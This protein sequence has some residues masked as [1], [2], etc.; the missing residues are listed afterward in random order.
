MYFIYFIILIGVLIF[1]HE[2]GHFLGAK[3]FKVKVLKLSLGFGPKMVGFRY[4]ETEYVITWFPL[5]GFVKMLGEDPKQEVPPQEMDRCFHL[6]PLWQRFIIVFLG[7][8]F[9]IL[10]PFV[11]YFFVFLGQ[12]TLLPPLVGLVYPDTPA[13]RAGFLPDDRIIA[14]DGNKIYSFEDLQRIISPYPLR[15]FEFLIQRDSERL[16]IEVTAAK[17]KEERIPGIS[18]EVGRIGIS[19]LYLAPR[20]GI[21][22]PSSPFYQAG[23]RTW[24]IVI[25]VDKKAIK[26][27]V[28]LKKRL[29]NLKGKKVKVV[30]LRMR[31][32][33]IGPFEVGIFEP[34][35]VMVNIEQEGDL[36]IEHSDLFIYKVMPSTPAA[37]MG[38]RSG[39]Q[40]LKLDGRKIRLWDQFVK[41]CQREP[42]R[43]HELTYRRGL[44]V[45]RSKFR[46]KLRKFKDE[47][48]QVYK[49]YIFGATNLPSLEVEPKPVPNLSPVLRAV[50]KGFIQTYENLGLILLGFWA[51][52]KGDISLKSIGGPI[53]IFDIAAK[54][55]KRGAFSFFWIMALISLNLALINLFP[56]PVLDGGHILL[57]CVE[58]IKRK[59]LSLRFKE[60]LTTIGICLL[61]FLML[62][63]FKN[64]LERYWEDIITWFKQI[65]G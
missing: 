11:I 36:K 34:R 2:I 8:F 22:D 27:W 50:S 4:K 9:N 64:D 30:F 59:P 17:E 56:I 13:E 21:S 19:P 14:I 33:E 48:K 45:L 43:V 26:T 38:L 63:A 20:I 49:E 12:K 61:I 25:S 28:E 57:F 31:K 6:K 54:A 16:R 5:G 37:W 42:Q 47:F 23:L 24:D 62:L 44:K 10:L 46:L 18:R 58:G 55:G 32:K 15:R 39:D 1:V 3:L 52:L 40:I 51:L 53:M 7:P 65:F 35:Q 41:M 60:V 29:R